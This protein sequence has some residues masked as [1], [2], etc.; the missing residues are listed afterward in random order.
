MKHYIQNKIY[1]TNNT[2]AHNVPDTLGFARSIGDIARSVNTIHEA[3]QANIE[4]Q[5]EALRQEQAALAANAAQ[6]RKEVHDAY[7]QEAAE[8]NSHVKEMQRADRDYA[9]EQA[10]ISRAEQRERDERRKQELAD[11]KAWQRALRNGSAFD[12]LGEPQPIWV[13]NDTMNSWDWSDE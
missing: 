1:S 6:E 10:A 7:L 13:D 9:R 2:N 4:K 5:N 8:W 11:R 12:P 3:R